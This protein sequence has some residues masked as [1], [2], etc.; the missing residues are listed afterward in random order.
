M[1]KSN[2]Q[3]APACAGPDPH[4]K[5]P[6]LKAPKGSCDCHS[7]ILG[8]LDKYPY[9]ENR[10]YTPPVASYED[11]TKMLGILGIDRAVVVHPSVYGID[12]RVTLEAVKRGGDN[13]RGVVVVDENI[14]PDE[15][16]SMNEIGIRGVRVNLLFDGGVEVSVL[17][18]IV[19]LIE[20]FG[21]HVQLLIDVSVFE[22]FECLM[23][24]PVDVVFD[25]M[26]HMHVSKGLN[27]PGFRKMVKM[28]AEG[29]AWAKL[30]GA[31]RISELDRHP[32]EDT[33]IFAKTIIEANEDRVVWATDWPHPS[34]EIDMPNDGD[35]LDILLRWAPDENLRKKIL[36]DNPAKLYGF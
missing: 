21:W 19:K 9:V 26:G 6:V 30:S 4:T 11:Y 2:Y 32:F 34:V 33:D 3:L 23:N 24:L 18:K 1:L 10:S 15:I 25:H 13:F 12:N 27:N 17:D 14:T 5:V 29:R 7:H 35:L 16:E 28:I 22:P 20:P 36:V 31:Y 8:P